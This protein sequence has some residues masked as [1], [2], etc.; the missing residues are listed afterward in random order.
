LWEGKL[1]KKRDINT[2]MQ[3]GDYRERLKDRDK[4]MLHWKKHWLRGT[5]GSLEKNWRI[6]KM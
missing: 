6:K 3:S 2:K 5:K 1:A 4:E